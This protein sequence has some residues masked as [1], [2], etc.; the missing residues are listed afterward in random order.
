MELPKFKYHPDPVKTGSF[1]ESDEV[2]ESCNKK[3]GYVYSGSMVTKNRPNSIC[4]WCIADG[5]AHEK[6][7]IEFVSLMPAVIDSKNPVKV[8][9]SDDAFDELERRKS[10]Y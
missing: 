6:F 8:E 9:C 10:G 5:S 3:T 2:C 1:I 7:E 4:P